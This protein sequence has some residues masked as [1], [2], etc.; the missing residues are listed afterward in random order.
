MWFKSKTKAKVKDYKIPFTTQAH[1]LFKAQ[2]LEQSPEEAR[3]TIRILFQEKNNETIH[4]K[5]AESIS[6]DVDIVIHTN[7]LDTSETIVSAL[8]TLINKRTRRK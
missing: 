6:E 1:E 4:P 3:D 7:I 8:F 5:W 2:L